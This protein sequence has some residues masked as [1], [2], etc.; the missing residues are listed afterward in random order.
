M[1]KLI[2]SRFAVTFL[3]I[4]ALVFMSV[5]F[6]AVSAPKTV[7]AE[8][9]V[10]ARN[11]TLLN[12]AGTTAATTTSPSFFSVNYGE[13]DCYSSVTSM[14]PITTTGATTVTNKIQHSPN[15]VIWSDLT[16]FGTTGHITTDVKFTN[17]LLYGQYIRAV[18][19]VG[20]SFNPITG[21]VVCTLKNVTQ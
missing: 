3:S 11:V 13:A 8:S 5:G 2:K 9:I 15:A 20:N 6:S 12:F 10:A 19:V 4:V 16:S 18:Q 1:D 7:G 21:S 17:T 14:S